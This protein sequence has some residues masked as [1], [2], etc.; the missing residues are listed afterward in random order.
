MFGISYFSTLFP[1]VLMQ[2]LLD[3]L[4]LVK[5]RHW[6]KAV[7][8]LAAMGLAALAPVAAQQLSCQCLP[9]LLQLVT[10]DVLEVR[11]GAVLGIAELVPALASAGQQELGVGSSVV[12]L[13]DKLAG[14]SCY[15]GKGGELMR[16]MA[17]RL[18]QQ[19]AAATAGLPVVPLYGSSGS[20]KRHK[21]EQELEQEQQQQQQSSGVVSP[22]D[23]DAGSDAGSNA[24]DDP[25][26][27]ADALG[28]QSSQQKLKQLH[29]P[30]TP[31]FHAAAAS[32]LLD[33][34]SH[35]QE[36]IQ[37]AGVSALRAYAAAFQ[38]QQR[39]QL[40]QLVERC[41]RRLGKRE[42]A[43]AVRRGAAA[44]LGVMPA[45]LLGDRAQEV[46]GVL[47]AA[48]QV[49]HR[50]RLSSSGNAANAVSCCQCAAVK[51]GCCCPIWLGIDFCGTVALQ[52]TCVSLT[53]RQLSRIALL[54]KSICS[55][56]EAV[57]W[58]GAAL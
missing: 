5:L 38:Q 10:D 11:C 55:R 34:I 54:L 56:C 12:M 16:E 40:L 36:S 58:R 44:A 57:C 18:V 13:L 3:H 49:R 33:C 45:G 21:A 47:V 7:R 25:A 46:L 53:V 1:T 22:G 29:L 30:L 8:A 42:G 37:A 20:S 17:A 48:V 26:D 50:A 27:A 41:C 4:L 14:A 31:E 2:A 39:E 51:Y 32:L 52:S 6:D 9:Q 28:S 19:V 43:A 15:K 24:G 35:A 23:A